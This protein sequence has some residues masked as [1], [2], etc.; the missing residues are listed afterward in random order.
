MFL[1]C[2]L[3]QGFFGL[4]PQNLFGG[5]V[6]KNLDENSVNSIVVEENMPWPVF[7]GCMFECPG[8]LN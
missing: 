1:I 3:V 4:C 8:N 7:S 6:L 5:G 2:Y